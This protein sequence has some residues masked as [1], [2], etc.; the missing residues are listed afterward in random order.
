[1]IKLFTPRQITHEAK[2]SGSP[3]MI[4]PKIHSGRALPQPLADVGLSFLKPTTRL[5]LPLATALWSRSVRAQ[6]IN[7]S[8]PE[9]ENISL[10]CFLCSAMIMVT[11]G[12]YLINQFQNAHRTI[13][14]IRKRSQSLSGTYLK[15]Q[16]ENLIKIRNKLNQHNIIKNLEKNAYVGNTA[17]TGLQI[18]SMLPETEN[19]DF[20]LKNKLHEMTIRL[21]QIKF[22]SKYFYSKI[23]LVNYHLDNLEKELKD[24]NEKITDLENN[25]KFFI[26]AIEFAKKDASSHFPR[27][28]LEEKIAMYNKAGIVLNRLKKHPLYFSPHR[29]WEELDALR[30]S[31]PVSYQNRIRHL[32]A[33][34]EEILNQEPT[35]DERIH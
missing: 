19:D 31:D 9:T 10:L 23:R 12:K 16:N 3:A 6:P 13:D 27:T 22:P 34:E 5:L 35:D 8:I 15:P 26:D 25:I 7:L 28:R 32:L 33:R 14:N 4:E 1:M 30:R 20:L 29:L 17:I 2:L 11:S 24:Q 18:N 21:N